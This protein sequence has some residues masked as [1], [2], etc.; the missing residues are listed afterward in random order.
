VTHIV[1]L[2]GQ[3]DNILMTP[4]LLLRLEAVATFC[5][6]VLVFSVFAYKD[7]QCVDVIHPGKANVPKTEVAQKIAQMYK[8]Q[9]A[10]V[11]VRLSF[12]FRCILLFAASNL[13]FVIFTNLLFE[14]CFTLLCAT[15]C[16][17]AP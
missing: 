8:V 2:V 10:C 5:S 7:L 6:F 12:V 9:Q 3:A 13:L 17:V 1:Q 14:W 15:T 4:H 11:M 16:F